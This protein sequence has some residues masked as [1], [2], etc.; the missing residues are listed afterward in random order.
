MKKKKIAI[1]TGSLSSG[2]SFRGIGTYTRELLS[3]L[4]IKGVDF[5]KVDLGEYNIAHFTS[6]KPFEISL[7][8]FKPRNTKFVLTIYDLIPIIFPS[9]YPSGF[10]GRFYWLLNR[11]LISLYVDAIITISETSKKDICRI[12]GVNPNKVYVTHLAPSRTFRKITD[13]K[14]LSATKHKFN[15]PDSFALYTGDINFN[16]NVPTLIEACKKIGITLVL[17]GK[18]AVNIENLDLTHSELRHLKNID[19]GGVKRLGYIK[20][21][22]LIKV[23]NLSTVFIMPSIYEG[24]GIPMV[25]AFATGTP[26]V[27]ARTQA[28]VEVAGDAACYASP[29]SVADFCKK[30]IS[31]IKDKELEAK[32]IK[33]GIAKSKEYTWEKTAAQT[34]KI[35]EKV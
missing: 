34:S 14:S 12:L 1:D 25:E 18:Q 10:K 31:V 19:W 5:A 30:I 29:D 21:D 16:K 27:A 11:L 35:Y 33:R 13:N 24:F 26:V 4:K 6:F 28:L 17:V 20:E 8:L 22:D 9:H 3:A 32:L 23:Y 2:H 15:L 7:P